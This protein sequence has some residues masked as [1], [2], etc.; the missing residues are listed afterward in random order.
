MSKLEALEKR[1]EYL[2][3]VFEELSKKEGLFRKEAV[4][5]ADVE[6]KFELNHR[7]NEIKKQIEKVEEELDSLEE[8]INR[9]RRFESDVVVTRNFDHLYKAL[10]KLGYWEQHRL[11]IS[12][13]KSHSYGA[14][15]IRGHSNEYGQRWLYNRLAL[16]I[17]K[18]LSD[19]IIT[20]DL[21]RRTSRS[22]IGAIWRELAGR[23]GLLEKSSPSQIVD[24]ICKLVR[25]QNVIIVFNNADETIKENLHDI[26]NNFWNLII[27]RISHKEHDS[28]I[29]NIIIFFLD[30]QGIV[31]QWDIGFTDKYSSDWHPSMPLG[32]PEIIPF[33]EELLTNWIEQQSDFLCSK[34][35]DDPIGM[36]HQIIQEMNGIPEPTFHKICALCDCNW[37]EQEGK[38]LRL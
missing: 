32:L 4:I 33:S 11:F 34:I 6:T 13:T 27:N 12:V 35:T 24:M 9:I 36:A 37:Y 19:K 38:W 2:E 14:F 26:L 8:Q 7:I 15:L 30:F 17:S 16:I 25:S 22:D 21:N 31:I 18:N 23:V 20:I 1:R 10:L 5:K 28:N 3:E 29:Y